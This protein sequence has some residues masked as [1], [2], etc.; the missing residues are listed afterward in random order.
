MHAVDKQ[1]DGCEAAGQ[2][3]TPPPVIILDR[4]CKILDA[5]YGKCLQDI[6]SKEN[7]H[8]KHFYLWGVYGKKG[9]VPL[10]TGGSSRAEL[11][12]QSR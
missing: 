2:E 12:P 3:G 4:D 11:L 10:H 1:V 5:T 8:S 9:E 6:S 7:H